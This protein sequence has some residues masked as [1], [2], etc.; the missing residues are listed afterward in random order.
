MYFNGGARFI[1]IAHQ[2]ALPLRP[3]LL[4]RLF[5]ARISSCQYQICDKSH[6]FFKVRQSAAPLPL[7]RYATTERYSAGHLISGI[8]YRDASPRDPSKGENVQA[9]TFGGNGNEFTDHSVTFVTA[10]SRLISIQRTGAAAILRVTR[11]GPQLF[12]HA[13]TRSPIIVRFTAWLEHW[14]GL[15]RVDST[16]RLGI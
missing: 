16:H 13:A 2:Y 14:Q 7:R 12:Q 4:S 5:C 3:S 1:R 6:V 11:G 10:N 8:E 9:S 15:Q